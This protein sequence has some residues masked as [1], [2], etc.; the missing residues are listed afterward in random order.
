MYDILHIH[1]DYNQCRCTCITSN[2]GY[3]VKHHLSGPYLSGPHLSGPYLFTCFG[4]FM[5]IFRESDSFIRIFSYPDSRLGNGGVWISEGPLYIYLEFLVNKSIFKISALFQFSTCIIH[6]HDVYL[7]FWLLLFSDIFVGAKYN[8]PGIIGRGGVTPGPDM[9]VSLL[10]PIGCGSR[11]VNLIKIQYY[12]L[13]F[14]PI[15]KLGS[16]L[17]NLPLENLYI[18]L[19]YQQVIRHFVDCFVKI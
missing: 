1:I 8:L 10:Y 17:L 2:C 4:P 12:I 3:T 16:P 7:D 13:L 19:D 5:I 6:V 11:L 9:L 15:M 18:Q 14:C